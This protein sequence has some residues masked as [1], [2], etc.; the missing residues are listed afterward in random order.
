M[1]NHTKPLTNYHSAAVA[2][3]RTMERK[4]PHAQPAFAARERSSGAVSTCTC[5]PTSPSS[6]TSSS[7]SA[8]SSKKSGNQWPWHR[9]ITN[10]QRGSFFASFAA[11]DNPKSD[12]LFLYAI[13][14]QKIP[15]YPIYSTIN[16][17]SNHS[18]IQVVDELHL[19][20]SAAQ[21]D[22]R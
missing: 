7:S 8:E 16:D 5:W 14:R 15:I 6:P 2:E 20:P 19:I 22:A 10:R 3:E 18:F 9:Q 21:V 11:V 4:A 1:P 17:T 13:S 12:P